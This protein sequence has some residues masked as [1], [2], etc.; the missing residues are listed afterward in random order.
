MKTALAIL[1]AVLIAVGLAAVAVERSAEHER[2]A[3]RRALAAR[4]AELTAQ[5]FAPGSPLACLDGAAGDTI[6]SGCEDALF[7]RPQTAAAAVAY[8]AARLDLLRDGLAFARARDQAFEKT[9][10]G[11]RRAIMLDRF[12]IAAHVL[13]TRDACSPDLCEAF[14]LVENADTLKSN[15]RSRVF[16]QYVARHR[17]AWLEPAQPAAPAASAPAPAVSDD[18]PM[19]AAPTVA[20]SAKYDFPSAASIPPVSIMNPEPKPSET[21]TAPAGDRTEGRASRAAEEKPPTPRRPQQSR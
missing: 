7:A 19:A 15:I 12:G 16:A 14:A 5:A 8:T 13:A 20:P 11:V 18:T 1:V 21:K 4:A 3:E 9:L 2:A 10:V 6:E 17:A